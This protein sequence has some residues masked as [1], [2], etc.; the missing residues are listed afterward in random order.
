M[1]HRLEA[2][3]NEVGPKRWAKITNRL[4]ETAQEKAIAGASLFTYGR[5]C[6][7]GSLS[8]GK[9]EI[10]WTGFGLGVSHSF[11]PSEPAVASISRPASPIWQKWRVFCYR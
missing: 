10:V 4:R 9:I 7:G 8:N 5:R 2:S 6:E 1:C 11:M 3:F